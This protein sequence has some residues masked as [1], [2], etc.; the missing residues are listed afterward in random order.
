MV[1]SKTARRGWIRPSKLSAGSFPRR[2]NPGLPAR[3]NLRLARMAL[4]DDILEERI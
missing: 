3:R 2:E 1:T 4:V